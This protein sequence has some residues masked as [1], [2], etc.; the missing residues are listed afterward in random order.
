VKNERYYRFLKNGGPKERYE[1]KR[2]L[3]PLRIII[4]LFP[5]QY[6]VTGQCRGKKIPSVGRAFYDSHGVFR[7]LYPFLTT[8]LYRY[9][10]TLNPC[11]MCLLRINNIKKK[12]NVRCKI[13]FPN[14]SIRRLY[15]F[16]YVHG[17]IF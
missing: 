5:F 14:T 12:H 2:V 3:S 9:N 11:I 10:P 17:I 15:A 13:K 4:I 8:L 6:S 1:K 7:S 16:P